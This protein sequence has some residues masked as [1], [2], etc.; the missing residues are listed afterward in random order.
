MQSDTREKA[1]QAREK[2]FLIGMER[3]QK[4]KDYV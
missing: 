2:A 4:R 3:K 1:F